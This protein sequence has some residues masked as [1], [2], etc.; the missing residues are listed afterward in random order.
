MRRVEIVAT[1]DPCLAWKG[2]ENGEDVETVPVVGEHTIDL[3]AEHRDGLRA[4]LAMLGEYADGA[5]VSVPASAHL[6]KRTRREVD[7]AVE[8]ASK[9]PNR[10]GGKRARARAER[11]AERAEVEVEASGLACP[12]CGHEARSSD[13]MGV[14][15]RS[16]HGLTPE[17]VYGLS[18]PICG[19]VTTAGRALGSHG[20]LMH[21]TGDG[22]PGLFAR[23]IADGDPLGIVAARAAALADEAGGA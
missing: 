21:S 19:K 15:L 9:P 23:A 3:C 18:C 16:A 8:R 11:A 13:A 10:R 7:R 12:V 22:V 20:R 1:C 2:V 14:H 6:P 17:A 4:V 5:A